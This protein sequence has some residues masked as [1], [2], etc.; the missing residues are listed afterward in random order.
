[1]KV[2]EFVGFLKARP[3]EYDVEPKTINGADGVV[4]ENKMFSTKTHFTGAAIEGND[5]VA[6]LT[7]THHGKNTTHMTRIT[8][9][10]SRIEGWNKGKLGELRDRYKNEGH[11]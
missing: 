9:Y 7:A 5:M 2:D 6:L 3:A 8:G 10:F 4:V 1:M 11:F